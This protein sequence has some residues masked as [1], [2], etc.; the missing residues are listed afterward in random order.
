MTN[1]FDEQIADPIEAVKAK[2]QANPD[3]A[4][5]ALAHSQAH[6]ARLE[7]EAKDKEQRLA[8]Q[9]T[10]DE[11]LAKLKEGNPI[12]PQVA[13]VPTSQ[14][15]QSVLDDATLEQKL[16]TML[17]QKAESE[18]LQAAKALV[19]QTLLDKFETVDKA[20]QVMSTKAKELGMT[21]EALDAIALNSPPAFF[22]LIGLENN[23]RPVNASPSMGNIRTGLSDQKPVDVTAKYK[24]MITTDRNKYFSDE[25][26]TA[27]M[28]DAFKAAGL[29]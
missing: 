11:V 20:K 21:V 29:N 7:Q 23:V 19:S 13:P 25:V 9:A 27:I 16:N 5:K 8:S 18:R 4:W 28:R 1:M 26:Q 3:E 6:I 22:Q 12:T 17:A 24:E 10:L 15:T 14:N 2:Y